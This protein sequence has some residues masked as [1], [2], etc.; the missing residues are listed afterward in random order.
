MACFFLQPQTNRQKQN[1]FNP[2]SLRVA[3]DLASQFSLK[4]TEVQIHGCGMAPFHGTPYNA[5]GIVCLWGK[6]LGKNALSSGGHC[7]HAEFSGES[8]LIPRLATTQQVDRLVGQYPN[9]YFP[10]AIWSKWSLCHF[11]VTHLQLASE[12][13]HQWHTVPPISSEGSQRAVSRWA[14]HCNQ[15]G[16]NKGT[17]RKPSSQYHHMMTEAKIQ[18][19][20]LTLKVVNITQAKLMDCWDHLFCHV[21]HNSCYV[22]ALWKICSFFTFESNSRWWL[23][24]VKSHG[25]NPGPMEEWEHCHERLHPTCGSGDMYLPK[26]NFPRGQRH[27]ALF[28]RLAAVFQL[29]P[30]STAFCIFSQF[31]RELGKDFQELICKNRLWLLHFGISSS[32]C[33]VIWARFWALPQIH[34]VTWGK[35]AYSLSSSVFQT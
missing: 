35:I 2:S 18:M 29:V 4:P 22:Y 10:L 30:S 13:G 1:G 14:R 25:W 5:G 7:H 33:W 16:G 21:G 8:D 12:T 34:S 17:D 9:G 3:W 28:K 11:G 32:S 27:S 6:M 15:S 26:T 20:L 31:W 23:L 24:L 19:N